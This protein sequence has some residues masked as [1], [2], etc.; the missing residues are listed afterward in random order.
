MAREN[1]N[2]TFKTGAT[3]PAGEDGQAG[4]LIITGNGAP[5]SVDGEPTDL[6]VDFSTYDVYQKEE[7]DATWTL[8]GNIKGP[9]GQPATS[10]LPAGGA[11]GQHLA[12][13]SATDYDA[14]WVAPAD[15]FTL[16]GDTGSEDVV[17]NTTLTIQGTS[18]QLATSITGTTMTLAFTNNVTMP[19]D[20]TVT[21]DLTVAGDLL[22]QGSTTTITT[23]VETSDP[24]IKLADGNTASDLVDIGFYGE[25]LAGQVEYT[26]LFRDATDGVF[27]LFD[28][29]ATEPTS[30]V[31]AGFQA[32]D[33]SV[34]ALFASSNS[35]FTGDAQA[36]TVTISS[37]P[38]VGVSDDIVIR[39]TVS[40]ELETR[41]VATVG[42][43]TLGALDDV[44]TVGA[45]Q[46]DLLYKANGNWEDTAGA[47]TWNGTTLTASNIKVTD[48]GLL[49]VGS[50]VDPDPT[51]SNGDIYYNTTSNTFRVFENSLWQNLVTSATPLDFW[52]INSATTLSYPA[53]GA[54]SFT[55]VDGITSQ[56]DLSGQDIAETYDFITQNILTTGRTSSG[57]ANFLRFQNNSADVFTVS[58]LGLVTAEY[59][60]GAATSG[61]FENVILG[62]QTTGTFSSTTRSQITFRN[63]DIGGA[64]DLARIIGG[65][66]SIGRGHLTLSVDGAG[67]WKDFL[68]ANYTSGVNLSSA[69]VTGPLLLTGSGRIELIVDTEAIQIDGTDTIFYED[70]GITEMLRMERDTGQ[71]ISNSGSIASNIPT[72]KVTTPTFKGNHTGIEVVGGEATNQWANFG[73]HTSSTM[74]IWASTGNLRFGNELANGRVT[75]ATGS[76]TANTITFQIGANIRAQLKNW[77][78]DLTPAAYPDEENADRRSLPITAD[79][80]GQLTG[81]ITDPTWDGLYMNILDTGR[82][83]TGL[84]NAIR[85]QND[86]ADVFRVDK[87]GSIFATSTFEYRQSTDTLLAASSVG[88]EPTFLNGA[89]ASWSAI[90]GEQHTIDGIWANNILVSGW[91]HTIGENAIFTGSNSLTSGTDNFMAGFYSVVSGH[92]AKTTGRGSF[93]HGTWTTDVG[94]LKPAAQPYVLAAAGAINMS[95]NT[96]SQT[97]GFGAL[98]RDSAIIGGVDSHI[99]A[100]S[101]RSVILGG[102]ALN[103]PAATTDTL[104]VENLMVNGT[105]TDIS[106]NPL[107]GFQADAQT[108]I[109][110]STPI[111]LAHATLDEIALD[112]SHTVALTH[113]GTATTIF[114]DV[115]GTTANLTNLID[116]QVGGASKFTVNDKGNVF[117]PSSANIGYFFG[118]TLNGMRYLSVNAYSFISNNIIQMNIGTSG[119]LVRPNNVLSA[120]FLSTDTIFY[121]DDGI[122]VLADFDRTASTTWATFNADGNRH[123]ELTTQDFTVWNTAG[124]TRVFHVERDNSKIIPAGDIEFNKGGMATI[125]QAGADG[126]GLIFTGYK[127]ANTSLP[128]FQFTNQAGAGVEHPIRILILEQ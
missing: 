126:R 26:G 51:G 64:A 103:M 30:T 68:W 62:V 91:H 75:L 101:L 79:I 87:D 76:S 109:T 37:V 70:D 69:N 20:L 22:V 65:E 45:A 119:V 125:A 78:F 19:N 40:G 6:Y 17:A 104:L 55:A 61:D 58:S 77:S 123:T 59:D 128:L 100:D 85:V 110:P 122:T 21:N 97:D 28:A 99:P 94:G 1:I 114:A 66:N 50:K 15:R 106:G 57:A 117:I 80:T 39:N 8:Q 18:N 127:I 107:S 73:Y 12:K 7:D 24:L 47:L 90:F 33:L 105:L 72:I 71:M 95:R 3:G 27:K 54:T 13:Q 11:I 5:N 118:S 42:R 14:V 82:T 108:Q 120:N 38:T 32:A 111:A 16:A 83:S 23:E 89:T 53:T 67:G 48:G 116:L 81:H 112:L 115:T 36:A 10:G 86:G 98:A 49:E 113:A 46:Y 93:A 124:T 60:A 4:S 25:Y 74:G 88:L 31:P 96:T 121:E 92:G 41:D 43:T 34:G 63:T 52:S 56:L 102:N 2:I 35:V 44:D 29:L 9:P 84:A